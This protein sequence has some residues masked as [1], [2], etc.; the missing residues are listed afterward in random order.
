MEEAQAAIYQRGEAAL[1]TL[2]ARGK[3]FP[4]TRRW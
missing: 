1:E 2:A 4:G 3:P